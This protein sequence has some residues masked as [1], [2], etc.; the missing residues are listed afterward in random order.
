MAS[1]SFRLHTQN[2]FMCLV[3]WIFLNA[4]FTYLSPF[5]PQCIMSKSTERSSKNPTK[6]WILPSLLLTPHSYIGYFPL[7]FLRAEIAAIQ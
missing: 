1:I 3:K 6:T 2:D 5:I 4:T 7:L